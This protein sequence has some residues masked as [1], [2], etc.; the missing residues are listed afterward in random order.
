MRPFL[1]PAV[2]SSI[3][4]AFGYPP[5]PTFSFQTLYRRLSQ[6][7]YLIYPGKLSRADTFRIGTI[8]QVFPR[9]VEQLVQAIGT[10]LREMNV[11]RGEARHAEADVQPRSG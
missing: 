7:G 11:G 10:A 2:Q 5:T 6:Q 1:R 4:T 8:G 9:D 3:I